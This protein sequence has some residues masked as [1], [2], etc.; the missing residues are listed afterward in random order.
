MSRA[1]RAALVLAA[2]AGLLAGCAHNTLVEP[3]P[4]TVG[5][6]YTVDPQVRWSASTN[7]QVGIGSGDCLGSE[8][9]Q[10]PKGPARRWG[11]NPA[12]PA[13]QSPKRMTFRKTMAPSELAELLADTLTSAGAQ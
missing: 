13:A 9:R 4:R 2:F 1:T 7:G 8:A 5:D 6:L 3:R 12:G 11:L 10:V